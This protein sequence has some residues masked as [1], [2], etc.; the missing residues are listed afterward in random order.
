MAARGGKYKKAGKTIPVQ[1][2]VR[3]Q[4]LTEALTARRGRTLSDLTA[5]FNEVYAE[6][7]RLEALTKANNVKF[8]AL[9]ILIRE[10]INDSGEDY[11]GVNGFTW[12]PLG[13]PYPVIDNP[14]EVIKYFD[15]D[16]M[17]DQLILTTSELASRVAAF[18]KDE[19]V[20]GLLQVKTVKVVDPETGAES[21]EIEVRSSIP[22]VKVYMKPRLGRTKSSQ[23]AK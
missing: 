3:G 13:T 20:K 9:E 18:V 16:E 23:G 10:H 6:A 12:T 15:T 22:G 5:E 11:V 19:A 1:P 17:R 14:S 4:A 2:T 8:D 7:E 21:D